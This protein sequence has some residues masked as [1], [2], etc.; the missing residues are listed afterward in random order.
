MRQAARV[1]WAP[2]IVLTAICAA[3]VALVFA[4]VPGPFGKCEWT[5][6]AS[7]PQFEIQTQPMI[8]ALEQFRITHGRYPS[9][10]SEAGLSDTSPNGPWRYRTHK[11]GAAYV[12]SIGD[13]AACLWEISYSSDQ[14]WYHNH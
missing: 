6:P 9:S 3:A 10:L 14:G 11:A 12:L 5:E 4:Y 1:Q 13:Y 2:L 8:D 7:G